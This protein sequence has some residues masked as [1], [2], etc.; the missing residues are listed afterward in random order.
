MTTQQNTLVTVT[1]KAQAELAKLF[2]E[3]KGSHP[4]IEGLRLG[5]AGG[6][7]S[8]FSYVTKFDVRKDKDHE[9]LAGGVPVFIDPKSAIY[10]K[11][12]TLDFQGGLEGKG[13]VFNN[14]NA[15]STCGCGESF[16]L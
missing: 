8:G 9:L 4:D 2:A 1:D 5:V 16:S 3:E 14:P 6:G 10:L 7:C 11:G 15:T 13:F 12:I